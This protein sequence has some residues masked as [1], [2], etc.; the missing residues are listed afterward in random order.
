MKQIYK[1]FTI[2]AL[3]LLPTG[4]ALADELLDSTKVNVAFRTVEDMNLLGG[5]S[6]VNVEK[7]AEKDY[8]TYSLSEMQALVGGYNGQLWNQGEALV[9]VDGVPRDANNILPS[10]IAQITFMKS[11]QAV[12]LYGSRGAHGVI[13]IT[14]KRGNEQGLQVSVRGNA[15]LFVPKSYPKYLGSAEYATLYNEALANDGITTPAFTQEDIYNYSAKTNPFRYPDIN[16][17]SED[18]L[19]KNYMRYDATA[20]FRGGGKFAKYYANVGLYNNTDLIKFGEGKDNHTT[21]LN[22]RGNIDLTLNDWISGWV[23]TSASFYDDRKDRSDFWAESAKLRPTNPGADPLVPLIPISAIDPS[24]KDSW[25]YINN[26][27]YIVGGKYLLGG[28]QQYATNP[29]A[30]MYA[31]GHNKYT[32]RQFQFDLGLNIDLA[33]ILQ[34]LSFRAQYAVDYSTSYNTAIINEYATYK[35]TWD[36][37]LGHDMISSL[38]KYNLD[39]RTATQTVSDSKD[40]QT[41]TF[42]ANFAYN[43]VFDDVHNVHAMLLANGYQVTTSGEYHRISNANLGLNLEYDYMNK[44]YAQ[45]S[46]AAVHSA[47]LAPGH[48]NAFSPTASL[49]WRISQEDWFENSEWLNDLKLTASYGILNQDIDIEKYY[50]YA[51]IFTSTG[52]YWGWSET[53]NAMQSTESKR[54][55]NPDLGFVKRK[56]FNIGLNSTLFDGLIRLNANFFNI[57]TNDQLTIA[58]STY[59]NYFQTYWPESDLRPYINYNNQRRT[60]FDFGVNVFK[61]VGEVALGLGVNG[62]YNK[63]KNLR[64]NETV[65]YDWLRQTGAPVDALRG[66]ECLGFFADENDVANSAKINNN[67]RP[68]DLK[69]RDQNGD[70]VID[71][72]DMVVLGKW[73]APFIM[74]LNF[75]AK[76]RNFTLFVAGTGNWGGKAFKNGP[77]NWVYGDVKYSEVVRG[78]WTPETASTATYP[79]LTTQGGELNFVN[80][81][82]W[83]YSTDA[84]Y[85]DKVQL[86]YDLPSSLFRDKFVKGLQVYVN[87]NSLAT[88]SK[89]RKQL[90]RNVGASPQCR[91]YTLGVKVDF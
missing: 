9:L 61:E 15:Q 20:E 39:K 63:T 14:T 26:S 74:G 81:D 82:F 66:Y 73:S 8:T 34:G 23:N 47:K 65:E 90:E 11:A 4:V 52:A 76:W 56:E 91:V 45:F 22:V 43:R 68:G 35:A 21:R 37:A 60:G 38:T 29:F 57:D 36:N 42:N 54:G 49:G 5:V 67:T 2:G 79:R 12:V 62:M 33:R 51:D 6:A 85:L 77:Y 53:N 44:Y 10:E 69:Y 48:R 18:Y 17:F 64:I 59:P 89:E 3:A 27:N 25:T 78:R 32:S 46:A 58:S 71:S 86:T 41:I 40:R 1:I 70:G 84:F 55:G 88:I 31:A 13:L 50:M 75:T 30:G 24:D 19:K 16:F 28:T 80:S 83:M 87:G 7:L 72:K